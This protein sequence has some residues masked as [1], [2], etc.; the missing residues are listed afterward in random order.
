M[1]VV[2]F[3]LNWITKTLLILFFSWVGW[4]ELC[5]NREHVSHSR[6]F[7]TAGALSLIFSIILTGLLVIASYAGFLTCGVAILALPLI[8]FFTLKIADATTENIFTMTHNVWI[9]IL[10][11]IILSITLGGSYSQSSTSRISY[12]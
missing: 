11:G 6:A 2:N 10:M 9:Q 1:W 5:P 4:M 12:N 3:A 7:W 8:G